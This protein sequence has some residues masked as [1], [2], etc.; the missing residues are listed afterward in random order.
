VALGVQAAGCTIINNVKTRKSQKSSPKSKARSQR[1]IELGDLYSI[2]EPL[3]SG[4]TGAER[5]AAEFQTAGVGA[6]L[7]GRPW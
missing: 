7:N 3:L 4:G 1:R 5:V 6:A 2:L